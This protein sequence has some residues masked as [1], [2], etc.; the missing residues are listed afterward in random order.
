GG[1][2][3]GEIGV[4]PP[5][6]SRVRVLP[7][8]GPSPPAAVRAEAGGGLRWDHRRPRRRRRRRRPR[9][10]RQ[11]RSGA[12]GSA[13]RGGPRP[14]HGVLPAGAARLRGSAGRDSHHAPG[15]ATAGRGRDG[16]DHPPRAA[17]GP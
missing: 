10:C 7:P 8:P 12:P 2:A 11:R 16:D 3:V 4:L 5:D 9:L 15:D 17:L 6:P 14:P 13:R 1:D